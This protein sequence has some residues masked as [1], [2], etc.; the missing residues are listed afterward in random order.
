MTWHESGIH[1][2]EFFVIIPSLFILQTR[3]NDK[4]PQQLCCTCRSKVLKW[5]SFKDMVHDTDRKL[6]EIVPKEEE[7]A[8]DDEEADDDTMELDDT[9][10]E[11]N[12]LKL[13]EEDEQ[14][15]DDPREEDPGTKDKK[16]SADIK[17][18]PTK[19][20]GQ[21]PK[22]K[23]KKRVF[24]VRAP[25]AKRNTP[26]LFKYP[27]A[28]KS[29]KWMKAE[30]QDAVEEEDEDDFATDDEEEDQAQE[31]EK[32][33]VP[34]K[35]P[36]L[37]S[38]VQVIPHLQKAPLQ[39]PLCNGVFSSVENFKKHFDEEHE[40]DVSPLQ[41]KS[42]SK[43]GADQSTCCSI[44]MSSRSFSVHPFAGEDLSHLLHEDR[45]FRHPVQAHDACAHGKS[46][47]TSKAERVADQDAANNDE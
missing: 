15:P 37:Q 2:S 17:E 19:A 46:N 27:G 41:I 23:Y 40:D 35:K 30:V 29:L 44:S 21:R 47:R 24:P 42:E 39:C 8:K 11:E 9:T 13:E 3:K 7:D 43:V 36:K 4:Y 45:L 34:A 28:A 20:V 38:L 18:D 32:D 14:A 16:T 5:N 1:F 33:E 10:L 31:Q 25:R 22:K 6:G 12:S 26:S